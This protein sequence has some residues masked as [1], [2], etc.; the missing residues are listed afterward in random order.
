MQS[1][2]G[3]RDDNCRVFSTA[4][5]AVQSWGHREVVRVKTFYNLTL[6]YLSRFPYLIPIPSLHPFI[7]LSSLL[8]LAAAF[9]CLPPRASSKA[10]FKCPCVPPSPMQCYLGYAYLY[11]LLLLPGDFLRPRVLLS[12]FWTPY[13]EPAV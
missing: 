11:V 6:A 3:S 1:V 13:T 10:H 7:W 5:E 2:A 9:V 8:V 12:P 4:E